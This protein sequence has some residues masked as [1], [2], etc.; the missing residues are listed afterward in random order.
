MFFDDLKTLPELARNSG[1]TIFAL[2]DPLVLS[3]NPLLPKN[4]ITISPEKSKITIDKVRNISELCLTRQTSDFFVLVENAE[5]MNEQAQNAFL[6]LL[7]EPK[8]NY[9]FV[10]TVKSPS[11]LLPTI[12]SRGDLIVMRQESPLSQ[13]ISASE[14]IKTYAKRMI[15]ASSRDLIQLMTDITSD[16]EYKRKENARPFTLKIVETAIE[17]TYKS[18]FKTGNLKLLRKLPNLLNLYENLSKNGHI[19]LH[20]VAD[21]W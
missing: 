9:H 12:L 15:T 14:T 4:T 19:K 5:A 17:M 13:P 1:F 11:G 18:Y 8:E 10:F 21:L 7:E 16:K 6:K 3:L 20:L 2:D